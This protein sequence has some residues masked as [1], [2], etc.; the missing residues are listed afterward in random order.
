MLE[1]LVVFLVIA[2]VAVVLCSRRDHGYKRQHRESGKERM[3][4]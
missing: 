1:I 2:L 4:G 3:E